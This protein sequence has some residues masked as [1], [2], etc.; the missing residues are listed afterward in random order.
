MIGMCVSLSFQT[1]D[2]LGDELVD[3]KETLQ[4]HITANDI[5]AAQL[6]KIRYRVCVVEM[7]AKARLGHHDDMTF[8]C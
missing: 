8:W 5:T 3:I 4:A 6:S 1:M 2:K 7:L